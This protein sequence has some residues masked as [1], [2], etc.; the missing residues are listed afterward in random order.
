MYNSF[1]QVFHTLRTLNLVRQLAQFEAF[2]MSQSVKHLFSVLAQW[3]IRI[4]AV[5][6]PQ[7]MHLRLDET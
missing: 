6:F 2:D 7:S 4:V 3:R 5:Q 1:D